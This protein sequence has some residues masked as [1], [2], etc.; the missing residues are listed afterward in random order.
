MIVEVSLEIKKYIQKR[1]KLLTE[2]LRIQMDI[3]TTRVRF[4]VI[5]SLTCLYF[6]PKERAISLSTL[7]AANV[8]KDT[9]LKHEPT[10]SLMLRTV[11]QS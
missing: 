5:T 11:E 2:M 4:R 10:T 1:L 7:I 6:S 9:P 3:T 8:S